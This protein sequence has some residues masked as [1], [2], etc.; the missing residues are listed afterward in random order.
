MQ[1]V[2]W[3]TI[4]IDW[5]RPTPVDHDDDYSAL[6]LR[7]Y[8][9][10]I[11]EILTFFLNRTRTEP[12]SFTLFK[13]GGFSLSENYDVR[14]ILRA[15]E[16][17]KQ[18]DQVSIGLELSEVRFLGTTRGQIPLLNKLELIVIDRLD[19]DAAGIYSY[20]LLPPIGSRSFPQRTP[21]NARRIAGN[22]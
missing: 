5:R 17:S 7:S 16:R 4:E 18:W 2:F 8:S 15:L 21:S 22:L 19:D 13:S 14:W 1:S 11:D 9:N 6:C 20:E 12:F 3:R 10:R